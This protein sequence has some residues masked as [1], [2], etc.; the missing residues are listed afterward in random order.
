VRVAFVHTV[1]GVLDQFRER[2]RREFPD[3]D[4]FH[5]LNE[6]LLQDLLRG[7]QPDEVFG[8]LVE[9]LSVVQKSGADLIVVTCSST[10]PGVD[11]ARHTLNVPV[12]KI[13]DPMARLAVTS[14]TRIG[15]VCTASSTLEASSA[16]L[17]QHAAAAGREIEI[18]SVLLS[19]AYNALFAGD[20]DVHDEIVLAAATELAPRVELLVLAQ[21]SLASLRPRLSATVSVPVLAS[22]DLLFSELHVI[23]DAA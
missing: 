18:E 21:A 5:V 4:A 23:L 8:R 1:G 10:S 20:R 3:I 12:L 13:D 17:R 15:L 19:K 11:L 22:P 7:T 14:A 6:G 16:L 9:Q 2:V